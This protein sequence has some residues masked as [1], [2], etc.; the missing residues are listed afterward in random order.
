M[1]FFSVIT[2]DEA[3]K[4]IANSWHC[5]RSSIDKPVL[6]S[7]GM[8][9]AKDI[10]SA[11]SV[12]GFSKST[13]DGYAVLAKNTFGASE[14]LPAYLELA[15]QVEM[16]KP[17]GDEISE[18]KAIK[19]PTGGMLPPGADAVVMLEQTEEFSDSL[20]TVLKSVAPGENV[21]LAGEDVELGSIVLAEGHR[22]KPVDIGLLAAIGETVVAVWEPVKVGIIST[23]DEIVPPNAPVQLGQ[24]KDIN[25]YTLAGFVKDLGGQATLYGIIPDDYLLLKEAIEKS[26]AENHITLV[27][28]GSSVGTRD[29][30]WRILEQLGEPGILFH[31]ISVKPGKPTLAAVAGDKLVFGLPGHPASALTAFNLLVADLVSWGEYISWPLQ[32]EKNKVVA[33]LSKGIASATG[34]KDYIP[35]TVEN[36][37]G[38]WLATPLLGKSGLILPIVKSDGYLVIPLHSGGL[39]PGEQV[40]VT[41]W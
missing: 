18:G 23:G 29:F 1:E 20:L 19:V 41:L 35:V 25:S 11:E 15:G 21:I 37:A 34:R 27:S 14:S 13:V 30:T 26:V 7:L 4:I 24:V 31:G 40:A 12:P 32:E 28:G 16:G 6:D 38:Q 10:K 36:V 9:L 8:V 5:Q 39:E 22:L 33:K 2:P 3:K 17:F